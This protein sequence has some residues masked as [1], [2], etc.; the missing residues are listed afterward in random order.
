MDA[1]S[2]SPALFAE[3][4][5]LY[6]TPTAR[7]Y[8]GLHH[9]QACL[10]ELDRVR[11]E[12]ASRV[13]VDAA[14]WALW[15][16]DCVYIAGAKD[17]EERSADVSTRMLRQ[18]GA[19]DDVIA[20]T[21]SMI[22]ATKHT[23]EPLDDASALVADVDMSILGALPEMYR[24]YAAA[25]RE[26]FSFVDDERYRAGR[27]AFLRGLLARQRIYHTDVFVRRFESKA[28]ANLTAEIAR[29]G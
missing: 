9:V 12:F 22:M 14:E 28:R 20:R 3:L 21:L 6:R 13:D 1:A 4:D 15:L 10:D 7:A 5:V 16:H 29:L 18:I 11:D 8:H 24:A 19:S 2:R 23:G 25:I 17:N 27:G 26:E